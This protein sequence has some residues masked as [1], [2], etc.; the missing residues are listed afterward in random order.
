KSN[1]TESTT[2]ESHSIET[3]SNE[4]EI[5]L[6]KKRKESTSNSLEDTGTR[7]KRNLL[8][9]RTANE[10]L[11]PT[12]ST[13]SSTALELLNKMA[14]STVMNQK[15]GPILF[16]KLLD[17]MLSGSRDPIIVSTQVLE[18]Q[19]DHLIVFEKL[20]DDIASRNSDSSIQTLVQILEILKN[21][22][23]LFHATQQLEKMLPKSGYTSIVASKILSRLSRTDLVLLSCSTVIDRGV[24]GDWH[25]QEL[26]AFCRKVSYLALGRWEERDVLERWNKLYSV[27]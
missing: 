24:P 16:E 10:G 14:S 27:C 4:P 15:N 19:E 17:K 22:W 3:T 6:S 12:Q 25:Q 13:E 2:I 5:P 11:I 7:K 8:I 21:Y 1:P 23:I 26:E 9:L 20:P 18:K